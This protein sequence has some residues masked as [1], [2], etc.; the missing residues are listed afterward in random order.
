MAGQ[1]KLLET[2]RSVVAPWECDVMGHLTIAYYFDRFTDAAMSLIEQLAPGMPPAAAWRSSRLLVR[3][4][5]ELRAG[6]GLFIRSG[7]IGHDGETLRLGHELVNAGTNEVAT[8]VEHELT[9]RDLPYGGRAEQRRALFA[10][11]IAWNSPGFEAMTDPKAK[12]RMV[13]SGADRVKAWEIDERGELS[14]AG[15]VHRFAYAAMHLCNAFGMSPPYMRQHKRGLSTF[16]TR[17]QLLAPPPGAGDGLRLKS[18]LLG[19]GNS[20]LRMLHELYHA[21]SGERLAVLHQSGVHFDMEARLSAPLP[22]E[23]KDRAAAL[24]LD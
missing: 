23:L 15:Y 14:L 4:Q 7:V 17:L 10:A 5:Q 1:N 12:E 21:K 16:D 8:L 2:Y 19:V 11:A 9:P 3:Y 18:G 13:D 20:S 22:P 6:D 24:V